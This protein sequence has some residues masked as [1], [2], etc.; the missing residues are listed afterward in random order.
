MLSCL[1]AAHR[2]S[3]NIYT[4]SLMG[5]AEM[6]LWPLNFHLPDRITK[7]NEIK[8]NSFLFPYPA[9]IGT[10]QDL[11][12][13]LQRKVLGYQIGQFSRAVHIFWQTLKTLDK[14]RA[15]KKS[16]KIEKIWKESTGIVEKHLQGKIYNLIRCC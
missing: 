2:S 10:A 4:K 13:L 16:V 15:G 14:S 12:V 3:A 7:L 9:C 1:I 5:T 8:R 6:S 11:F